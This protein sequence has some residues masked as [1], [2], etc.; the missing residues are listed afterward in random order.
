MTSTQR[1]PLVIK[2]DPSPHLTVVERVTGVNL[3]DIIARFCLEAGP[4]AQP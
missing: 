4:K 2:V 1:G 3:A